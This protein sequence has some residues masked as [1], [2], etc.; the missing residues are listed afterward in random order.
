MSSSKPCS[1][2]SAVVVAWV[3]EARFS[4]NRLVGWPCFK[5]LNIDS[6]RSQA[7]QRLFKVF[8][9]CQMYVADMVWYGVFQPGAWA[10]TPHVEM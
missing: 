10:R 4:Y 3:L 7:K 2:A 8:L 1:A 9:V 5:L 6:T